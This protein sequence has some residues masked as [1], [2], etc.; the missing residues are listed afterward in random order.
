MTSAVDA[1]CVLRRTSALSAAPAG[2]GKVRDSSYNQ[3]YYMRLLA[4]PALGVL[5]QCNVRGA[6]S[7]WKGVPH[8]QVQEALPLSTPETRGEHQG[9]TVTQQVCWDRLVH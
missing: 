5:R 4:D 6:A 7:G 9:R 3:L 1:T 8:L 2:A